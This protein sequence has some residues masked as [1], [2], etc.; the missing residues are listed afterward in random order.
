MNILTRH[1]HVLAW[2]LITF[3][4]RRVARVSSRLNLPCQRRH[5][6][7]D[8][9]YL[10]FPTRP[11]SSW[12]SL[13]FRISTRSRLRNFARVAS[14]NC[15]V[16]TI[17]STFAISKNAASLSS[18]ALVRPSLAVLAPPPLNVRAPGP[19]DTAT[20]A[21]RA[22]ALII[23]P[24]N[25]QASSS[26]LAGCCQGAGRLSPTNTCPRAAECCRGDTPAKVGSRDDRRWPRLADCLGA[27]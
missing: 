23:A 16:S 5:K 22:P 7:K 11:N 3:R 6:Y 8:S 17:V 18:E 12:I 27:G 4:V 20:M 24:R 14:L 15:A 25:R 13:T 26:R 21:S 2:S 1:L 19:N 10:Q 9:R